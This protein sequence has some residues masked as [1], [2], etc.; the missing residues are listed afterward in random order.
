MGNLRRYRHTIFLLDIL[1]IAVTAFGGPQVH[2]TLIHKVLVRKRGYLTEE[3]L[4]E[5]SSL[6]SMLPGPSSTQTITAIGFQIG[7]P[8]LAFL[9]LA[10][11]ILPATVLMSAFAFTVYF[12]SLD[13]PELQFLKFIQPMA[14]AFIIYAAY[15]IREL[16]VVKAYHWVLMILAAVVGSISKTPHIF[17][18]LLV[19][20]G[21]VSSIIKR[22]DYHDVKPIRNVNWSNFML[23]AGIFLFA[24][25]MGG[26]TH[27]REVLLFENTFRYGSI[28]FGGGHV[29][30]PMMYNQFVEFKHYLEPNEFLAGV[31]VLQAM[32]GPV[33]SFSTYTGALAM[34]HLGSS[35]LIIGSIIG[36]VGIFLPGTLLIFFIYPMWNQMKSFSPVRNAIDGINATSAG[37]VIASAFLLFQPVEVNEINM[38][39]L[40]GTLFL[41]LSTRIPYPVI[42]ILCVLLG[43]FY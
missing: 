27:A 15:K 37:L 8:T 7:G 10:A 4:R 26:V 36:T 23:F 34:Q 20:G 40:L 17:P 28:V 18:V 1:G 38:L 31:G 25:V 5:L 32:P 19:I 21:V 14:V 33:F 24:A 30:I 9:T 12:F 16:F 39:V 13:N 35:G 3:E 6:C 42:V 11:W 22:S 43:L 2:L 41:L 29:L